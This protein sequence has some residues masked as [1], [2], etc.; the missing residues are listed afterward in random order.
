MTAGFR[1]RVRFCFMINAKVLNTRSRCRDKIP[2][3]VAGVTAYDKNL[4][5]L[6]QRRCVPNACV[7]QVA[8]LF[9]LKWSAGARLHQYKPCIENKQGESDPPHK[10]QTRMRLAATTSP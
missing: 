5:V 4:A 10:S 7:G 9:E 8:D 2:T 6:Q 3:A 1:Q